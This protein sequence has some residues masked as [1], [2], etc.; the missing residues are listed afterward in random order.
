[1]ETIDQKNVDNGAPAANLGA[2]SA[3]RPKEKVEEFGRTVQNKIDNARVPAAQKL[4]QAAWALHQKA[5]KLPGG[6][7]VTDLAHSTA[8]GM[9]ATARYVRQHDTRGMIED[10]SGAV[11]KRPAQSL[12]VA[13]ALGFL[14]GF[15]LRNRG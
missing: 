7:K 15:G 14:V 6:D 2:E 1:M 8:A 5:D 10:A 4:E 3:N 13:A 9:E 12:L 11:R